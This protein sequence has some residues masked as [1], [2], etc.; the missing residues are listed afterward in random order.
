MWSLLLW[1]GEVLSLKQ[2]G[3]GILQ[4]MRRALLP[5][6]LGAISLA[7]LLAIMFNTNPEQVPPYVSMVIFLTLYG[8]VVSLGWFA[9]A[10]VRFLGAFHWTVKRQWRYAAIGAILPVALLLLQSIGQ[11]TIRDVALLFVFGGL[12]TLYLRRSRQTKERE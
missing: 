4:I 11:L 9:L 10:L 2:E 7:V 3:V 8:V 6:L 12:V 1:L 5:G